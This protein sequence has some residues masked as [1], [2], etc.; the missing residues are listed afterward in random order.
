MNG[1][2]GDENSGTTTVAA[3]VE[4]WYMHDDDVSD[5]GVTGNID[6]MVVT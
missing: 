2:D 3:E 1:N 5:G 6:M 4:M